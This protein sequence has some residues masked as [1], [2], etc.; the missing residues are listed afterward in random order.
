MIP[1]KFFNNKPKFSDSPLDNIGFCVNCGEYSGKYS[2][3]LSMD[4][5]EWLCLTIHG[6]IRTVSI[7]C[8]CGSKVGMFDMDIENYRVWN[9]GHG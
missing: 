9:I 7:N 3:K 5:N 2:A 4:F 8:E 1:K 6:Y